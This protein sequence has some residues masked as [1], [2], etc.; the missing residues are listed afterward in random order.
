MSY[1]HGPSAAKTGRA[2]HMEGGAH[3]RNLGSVGLL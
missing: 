3:N 1:L 2:K